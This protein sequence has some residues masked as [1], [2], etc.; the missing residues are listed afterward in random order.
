MNN[1]KV[2]LGLRRVKVCTLDQEQMVNNSNFTLE[3]KKIETFALAYG[4]GKDIVL[5]S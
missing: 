3:L 2:S 1:C 4:G 5:R